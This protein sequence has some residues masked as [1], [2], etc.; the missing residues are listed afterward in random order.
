[1]TH[2]KLQIDDLARALVL[3]H[4]WGSKHDN[5]DKAERAFELFNLL[6]GDWNHI[7]FLQYISSWGSPPSSMP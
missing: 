3:S 1:M 6:K 5:R 4:L 2:V 7:A